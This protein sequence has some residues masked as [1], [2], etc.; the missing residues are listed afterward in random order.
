[1]LVL[2]VSFNARAV[3]ESQHLHYIYILNDYS[4]DILIYQRRGLKDG[5]VWLTQLF[6][7]L[8]GVGMHPFEK[9]GGQ[10]N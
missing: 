8:L 3:E 10:I 7:L 6:W 2:I 9:V 1:M 5:W 4:I